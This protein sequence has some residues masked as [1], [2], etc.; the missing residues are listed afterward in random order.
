[1]ATT[2]TRTRKGSTSKS[3]SNKATRSDRKAASKTQDD[4]PS[5]RDLQRQRNAELRER[6][7]ELREAEASWQEIAEEIESTP[8]KAQ[9]LFMQHVVSK[10]PKL[11]I[12]HSDEDELVAGIVEAREAN[13]QHS[14][15]G[16]IAART[17]VSEGKV[18]ALAEEAGIQVAGTNVAVARAEANG[19]GTK[20][21]GKTRTQA[22]TGR[23]TKKGA[24]GKAAAAK[25]RA[26]KRASRTAD[27]S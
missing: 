4:G 5:K 27:P 21:D 24:T 7:V 25:K 8:G 19:G 13:D 15:W 14:S 6:V 16:W 26:A 23:S 12:K 22:K 20:A 11:R 10:T 1:M 17:G 3:A 18:K 9:F 2:K